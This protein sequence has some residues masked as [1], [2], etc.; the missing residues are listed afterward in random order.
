MNLA[1]AFAQ[2]GQRTLI[3]GANMR[4][5]SLYGTFGLERGPGLSDVLV[6]ETD[7]HSVVRD[8]RDLALGSKADDQLSTAPGSENLFFIT[9]GGR[10]L[11][12]AEWLS[13]PAFGQLVKET[14][15]EFDVVLIDGPPTLPVPDSV[16]MA[17]VVGKVV[18][19][20]QVGNT[21]RD[22]MQ[23]TISVLQNTGATILGLV[24][25]DIRSSWAATADYMHYRGYYGRREQ[26]E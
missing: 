16:V 11:H 2:A 26:Q 25:N 22:P 24:L 9:C 8:N 1:F 4:R 17:G 15:E 23:R 20:Y 5:P 21:Q 3:I 18:L 12:P 10:T 13:L 7:W 6:G 19:V 14:S